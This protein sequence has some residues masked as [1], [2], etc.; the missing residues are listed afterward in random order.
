VRAVQTVGAV[1]AIEV[2]RVSVTPLTGNYSLDLPTAAP[3]LL[4]YSSS[5]V[6]PLKFVAQP[7]SAGK[8]RLAAL[9]TGYLPALGGE[10]TV[11]FG[12]ILGGQDFTLAAA[13]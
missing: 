5:M 2:A 10:V 4:I 12:S 9:A 13:K 1:P 8:Y 7:A 3:R 6:T 11:L